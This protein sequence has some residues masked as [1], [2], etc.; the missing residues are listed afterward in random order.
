[1]A[2]EPIIVHLFVK[3]PLVPL[4]VAASFIEGF[5][6]FG[7]LRT[8]MESIST[9]GLI[10]IGMTIVMIAGGFDLSVGAVMAMGGV[11][12][13]V[14]LP[15]G[16][17]VS[18]LGA[19]LAGGLAGYLNGLQVTWLRINAFIATLS[20]MVIVRGAT[21]AYTDTRP[22]V[23]LDEQFLMLSSGRPVPLPFLV[24]VGISILAHVALTQ[25]PWGRHIYAV[26][27][28]ELA[29]T[30]SG[31]NTGRLKRQ[32]YI[33]SGALAGLAGVLLASRLGTGS[34]II[35]EATPLIAAAAALIG[36][37]SLRGGEGSVAGAIAGLIFVGCL[38]N[39]LNLL[40]MPSY[41]QRMTIGGLLLLLV[42]A[43]GTLM[44]L[45]P[46]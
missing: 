34:P 3:P 16:L 38:I 5:W 17:S 23:S 30:M 32:C 12:A 28:G 27:A 7:N 9:D 37:A 15:F 21:L 8:L 36:G 24:L 44:R 26:G 10:V 4:L 35:G 18:L 29:A 2:K 1:M 19:V 43:D 40:D 46:R 14:L 31:L 33:L 42:V 6:S 39:V 22:V 11:A 20:M 13:I 25:R 45:Q 41:Y